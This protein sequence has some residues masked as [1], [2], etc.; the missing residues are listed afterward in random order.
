M[1][2]Y[3]KSMNILKIIFRKIFPSRQ[4]RRVAP[5]HLINGDKTLRLNYDLS[6]D[7]VVFDIGAFEGSWASDIFAIY[8]CQIYAFEPVKQY[9]EALTKKFAKNPKIKIYP[10]GLSGKNYQTEIAVAAESSS[11]F[12]TSSNTESIRLVDITQFIN[13]QGLKHIDL[14]KINIEGGEYDLLDRLIS[15]E[16]INSIDNLQIQFHDFVPDAE[17]KVQKL[18]EQLAKTH[19]LTYQYDFVWENWSKAKL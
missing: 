18:R 3:S 19:Q 7:S 6:A 12:K 13:D 11:I 10:F 5:W 15:S 4:A 17:L 9:S 2:K 8:L 1:F 16:L 14:M